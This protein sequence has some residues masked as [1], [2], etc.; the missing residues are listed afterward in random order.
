M[1]KNV[2]RRLQQTLNTH[3]VGFAASETGADIELLKHIFTPQQAELVTRLD[4][5]FQSTEEVYKNT[6]D[7]ATSQDDLSR[8]LHDILKHGGL[9]Y[10]RRDHEMW[11]IA[12]LVVGMY[13]Y[14][15]N[16]MSSQFVA[17]LNQYW[18]SPKADAPVRDRPRQMR[19]IPIGQTI[20]PDNRI[21]RFEDIT[22]IVDSAQDSI[23]L[24]EC[25]CRKKRAMDGHSCERTARAESCIAFRDFAEQCI[26]QGAGR[27]ISKD[28]AYDAL[29]ESQAEGLVLMPS[30]SKTAEFVCSCCP[31]CCG[32]F[33]GLKYADAPAQVALNNYQASVDAQ[34]CIGCRSCEGI[35]PI[36]AVQLRNDT[37]VVDL[38]RCIGCGVCVVRCETGA[39]RLEPKADSVTPPD[40]LDDLYELYDTLRQP[41]QESE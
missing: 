3:P 19:V 23:A 9:N 25:I 31:D 18:Q 26:E 17:D 10:R 7:L 8:K 30:N 41:T 39:I 33:A 6:S 20:T 27:R 11:A 13:E 40:T 38:K 32:A 24:L 5:H 37:A 2:Y 22:H 14:Q 16:R 4:W 28:E 1:S 21:A 12:P 35:C 36:E 34:E 29:A 15:V